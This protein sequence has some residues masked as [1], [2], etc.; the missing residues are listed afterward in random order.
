MLTSERIRNALE[1]DRTGRPL[2][3]S[4]SMEREAVDYEFDE[5]LLKAVLHCELCELCARFALSFSSIGPT[6]FTQY[7]HCRANPSTRPKMF[8]R[9]H[10]WRARTRN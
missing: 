4:Y 7:G 8:V 3:F 5:G 1:N 10:C 9:P 2:V 6:C